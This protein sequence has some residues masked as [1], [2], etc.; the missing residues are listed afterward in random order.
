MRFKNLKEALSDRATRLSYTLPEWT[1]KDM[2][3]A[4]AHYSDGYL[5][6]IDSK[7]PDGITKF[8]KKL[9]RSF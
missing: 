8:I 6:A 2:E 7:A 5:D 1:V 9:A 3:V 4:L